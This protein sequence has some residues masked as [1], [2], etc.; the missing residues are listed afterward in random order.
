VA[1]DAISKVRLEQVNPSLAAAIA[2]M[3]VILSGEGIQFRVT[4]GLRT[5]AEQ[6]ALYAQGRTIPGSIVTNAKGGESWHNLGVAVDLVPMDQIPPQP[7]WDISHPVWQRMIQVAESLGLYSGSEFICLKDYPHL[8]ETGRFPIAAPNDEARQ[9]Y[10]LQGA[11][12]FW[13]EVNVS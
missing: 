9:I 6:N 2:Q 11:Q 12:A 8:Q 13:N 1:L 5:W 3:D 7:D 4:Q 10:S